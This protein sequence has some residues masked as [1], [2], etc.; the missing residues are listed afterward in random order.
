MAST[1]AD[2]TVFDLEGCERRIR[3]IIDRPTIIVLVRYFG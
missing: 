1:F 3:E 2:V